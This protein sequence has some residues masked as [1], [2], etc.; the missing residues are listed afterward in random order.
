MA[1][2]RLST[3]KKTAAKNVAQKIAGKAKTTATAVSGKATTIAKSVV[4]K[5]PASITTSSGSNST[6]F[7]AIVPGLPTHITPDAIAGMLPKFNESEYVISDPLNP[8]ETLPQVTEAQFDKGMTIYEG[9]QR[10]LKLT[11]AAFDTTRERFTTLG[12]QAKAFGAGVKAATEFE[13]VKGDYFDYQGQ[14]QTNEQKGI[15]LGVSQHKTVTDRTAAT[16]KTADMDEKLKQAEIA[17]N[18]ARATTQDKQNKL[19]EFR[20]SLGEYAA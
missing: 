13:R 6:T 4:D 16:H 3:A 11:G 20:K 19:D 8:P 17:A 1:R 5:I 10:A 14:L 12:K 9:T 2:P 7:S 18:L 15:A